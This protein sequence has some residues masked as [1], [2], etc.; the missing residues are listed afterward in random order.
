MLLC[1]FGTFDT[2]HIENEYKLQNNNNILIE[3]QL[4]LNQ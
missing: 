3:H 4:F 2:F 1:R